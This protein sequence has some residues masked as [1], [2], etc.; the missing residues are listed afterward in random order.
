MC[1][2]FA[3]PLALEAPAQTGDCLLPTWV[4][5]SVLILTY[6]QQFLP[7]GTGCTPVPRVHHRSNYTLMT[8]SVFNA[9]R[10]ART[11]TLTKGLGDCLDV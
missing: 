8:M 5:A 7:G 4:L 11:V 9:F 10:Q 2:W 6:L 3:D 1:D